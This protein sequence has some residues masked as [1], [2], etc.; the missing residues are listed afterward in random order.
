[1]SSRTE[2][3]NALALSHTAEPVISLDRVSKK[4]EIFDQPRDRL[5]QLLSFG[6]LRLCRDFWAVREAT[7]NVYPGETFG[8]VGRNGAGKSTLLQ[9][10]CGILLPTSGT[11]SIRGR[12]TGLLELGAGLNVEDTGRDNIRTMAIVLGM[13]NDEI[14]E[15]LPAIID[16]AG[17]GEFIDRPVKLYS[18]GMMMRLAFS[19]AVSFDPSILIIDEALA[20]GD[21]LFQAKCIR[22][23]EQIKAR[24]A[25]ILFVSHSMHAITQ[26]CDRAA[27]IDHGKLLLV[28]SAKRIAQEYNKL[29]YG[30]PAAGGMSSD[31][32]PEFAIPSQTTDAANLN[33]ESTQWHARSNSPSTNSG[34]FIESVAVLGLDYRNLTIASGTQTRFAMQ[35]SLRHA[36]NDV[37]M[38]MMIT[39]PT[40]ID[41]FHTNLLCKAKPIGTVRA[42]ESFTVVFDINLALCAGSY[43][44]V[45]DCQWDVL[46]EPK[47]A[48]IFYEALHLTVPPT[49]LV[50]DGGIAALTSTI[51]V[52]RIPTHD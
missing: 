6:R 33:K 30:S 50:E 44:A 32:N 51:S 28:D 47:L 27:L 12:V 45:F 26:I 1:M 24:G 52:Q 21:E 2:M 15:R 41:C 40:G 22:R 20:V 8:L 25:T 49:R 3:P 23:I 4:Y 14:Q 43:I 39:T 46:N 17:L 42:G 34:A 48:D 9:L 29:L 35:V 16:F 36:L 11:V 18:S 38:G 5:W 10:I 37:I 7:F 19:A 13:S 31:R